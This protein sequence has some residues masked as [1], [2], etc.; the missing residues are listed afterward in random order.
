MDNARLLAFFERLQATTGRKI[1][2]AFFELL[3]S[4]AVMD[5]SRSC[6]LLCA[7]RRLAPGRGL[8]QMEAFQDAFYAEGMDVL[9]APVREGMAARWGITADALNEALPDGQTGLDAEKEMALAEEYLG[10]FVVYPTLFVRTCDG[11][12]HAAA[13]GYGPYEKVEAEIV[14][15]MEGGSPAA[16]GPLHACGL[17]GDCR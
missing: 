4:E 5:S 16:A 9:S 8:E 17:D 6:R 13:R 10:D 11:A 15:I 3:K 2:P 12:L 7:L 1:G 14:R